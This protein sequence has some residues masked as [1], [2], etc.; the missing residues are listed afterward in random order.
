MKKKI[1]EAAKKL[2]IRKGFQNIKISDV[3]KEAKIGKGTVYLY[4]KHK[5]EI[6]AA[7]IDGFF[8]EAQE[9]IKEAREFKGSGFDKL[10]RFIELDLDF[11]ER[12]LDVF[13]TL[14]KD[15]ESLGKIFGKK[16]MGIV[17]EKYLKIVKPIASIISICKK[18]GTIGKIDS[19][20]G[21]IVLI[22]I[23][24]AYVGTRIY[25]LNKR[26]LREERD[27]ILDI[28]LGGVG[29]RCIPKSD[30]VISE[31]RDLG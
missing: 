18:E 13:G 15:V 12:H 3:A 11:Y 16:W 25:G 2:I 10:K 17:M 26:H 30:L 24:R 27:K 29:K 21:M 7:L 14:G 20:E 28:F 23:I 31:G 9:F 22:S 4:F 6:F 19:I 1:I 5:E 8:G